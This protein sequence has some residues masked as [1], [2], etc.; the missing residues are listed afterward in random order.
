MTQR[1]DI[2]KEKKFHQRSAVS[3]FFIAAGL[4]YDDPR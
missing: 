1:H 4:C 3:E 2:K